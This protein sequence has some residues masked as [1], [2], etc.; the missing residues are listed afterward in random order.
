MSTN[1][2]LVNICF[3]RPHPSSLG[4]NL[5]ITDVVKNVWFSLVHCGPKSKVLLV[6]T[7]K[8]MRQRE[9]PF[10]HFTIDFPNRDFHSFPIWCSLDLI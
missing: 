6:L 10:I 7:Q 3:T 9:G 2:L 8:V 5:H 1:N 4:Y